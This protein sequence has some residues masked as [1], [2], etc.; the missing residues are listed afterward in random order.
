MVEAGSRS[1]LGAIASRNRLEDSESRNLL[2]GCSA[3]GLGQN[4][5]LVTFFSS[6]LMFLRMNGG[7]FFII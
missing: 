6:K 3:D 1:L 4:S 5:D 7:I 2:V